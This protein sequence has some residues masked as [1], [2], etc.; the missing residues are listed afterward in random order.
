MKEDAL[1]TNLTNLCLA[2][3]SHENLGSLSKGVSWASHVNRKWYVLPFNMSWRYRLFSYWDE[4]PKNL[5]K[6]SAQ[7]RKKVHFRLT[8]FIQKRYL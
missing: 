6:K 4:M 5:G 7:E 1:G 2:N 3:V 8:C